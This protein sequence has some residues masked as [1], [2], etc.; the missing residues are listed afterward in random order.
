M[1]AFC[2]GSVSYSETNWQESFDDYVNRA[3][4]NLTYRK[5]IYPS[6]PPNGHDVPGKAKRKLVTLTPPHGADFCALLA[7][8]RDHHTKWCFEDNHVTY[9]ACSTSNRCT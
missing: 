4:N 2:K 5:Q 9:A 8:S 3:S 1:W 7:A 6:V